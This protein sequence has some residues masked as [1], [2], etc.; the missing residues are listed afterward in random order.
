MSEQKTW[1][2]AFGQIDALEWAK[3]FKTPM[4]S[5][6]QQGKALLLVNQRGEHSLAVISA[7]TV[8]AGE[9]FDALVA[10]IEK[11]WR[12]TATHWADLAR[13]QAVPLDK[14]AHEHGPFSWSVS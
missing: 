13:R 12:S 10:R 1:S 6:F 7:D 9:M 2:E 5:S 11:Q 14:A 8:T 4:S 3:F